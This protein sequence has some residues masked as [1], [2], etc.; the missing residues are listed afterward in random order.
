MNRGEVQCVYPW[1]GVLTE[2]WYVTLVVSD[3]IPLRWFYFFQN[4]N[5]C[6]I[7]VFCVFGPFELSI[8]LFV[9][10][11]CNQQDQAI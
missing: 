6:S 10:V 9:L 1:L 7:A 5:F 8:T 4:S 11:G 3:R 2:I